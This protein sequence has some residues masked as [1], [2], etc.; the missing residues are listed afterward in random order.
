[1]YE[2]STYSRARM[3]L[4]L[5]SAPATEPVTVD[6]CK[7]RARIDGGNQEPAPLA[8]TVALA[9]LGAG[10]LS[11]GVYRYAI[12]FLTAAGGT[13]GGA[14]S[15]AVTVVD[16]TVN[17]RV[18]LSAI[19]LG[20]SAVTSR[21]IY[22][23]AVNGT[24]YLL[25]ATL[26]NNTATTYADNIADASLGAGMPTTNTTEDP[27]LLL[28]IT[29]ARQAAELLTRR[30]FITQTWELRLDDFPCADN[31]SERALDIE[32]PRPPLV[33]VTSIT[34]LD[35]AGVRQTVDAATY[36]VDTSS[37]PGRIRP[38]W[39]AY[40][41]VARCAM[42]SVVVRYVAG[43]GAA[44]AVPRRIKDWILMRVWTAW[45]NRAAFV[46][47]SRAVLAE[48]PSAFVD[49]MLDEYVV[50]TRVFN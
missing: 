44:S 27:E 50:Y 18:A 8:P 32:L 10:N 42:G 16:A 47:D 13:E 4:T 21:E 9:G 11:V 14:V 38:V 28:F 15:A 3:A 23:T 7:A 49:G 40:W 33:S 24:A 37:E 25:L 5:Y 26:S 39:G 48:L 31:S 35:T 29:S 41:P 2:H 34:Y 6:E 46:L 43:Y 45:T 36:D 1:M 17:G 22:R 19:S 30:A 20:G 12:R